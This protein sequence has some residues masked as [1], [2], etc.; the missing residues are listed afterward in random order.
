MKRKI[1]DDIDLD[2]IGGDDLELIEDVDLDFINSPIG[3][4]GDAMPT[5]SDYVVTVE[6][7]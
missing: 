4:D 1:L 5:T 2:T 7:S 6:R 3:F